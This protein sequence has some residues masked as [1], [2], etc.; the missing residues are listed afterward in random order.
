MNFSNF[1]PF[2]RSIISAFAGLL[3]YGGW[4]YLVNRGHGLDA[5][6]MA[7]CVQGSYSFVLTFVMTILVEGVFRLFVLRINSHWIIN[8][9][10]VISSCAIIFSMSWWVNAISGTPEIFNTV[11]LGYIIGFIYCVIYVRGLMSEHFN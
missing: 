10:T 6:M 2:Q 7:A 4:G 1:T 9:S 11:I 3:F 8:L 5:A